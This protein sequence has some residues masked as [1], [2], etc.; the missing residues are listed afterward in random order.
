M[1]YDKLKYYFLFGGPVKYHNQRCHVVAMN[2]L[3]HTVK[4]EQD[5]KIIPKP[6][7]PEEVETYDETEV[8]K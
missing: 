1:N 6:I 8:N 4:L 2:D 7:K 5:G 3:L